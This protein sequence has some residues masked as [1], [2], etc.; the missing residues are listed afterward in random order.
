MQEGFGH[1]YGM[2]LRYVA[3]RIRYKAGAREY[4]PEGSVNGESFQA[5][6]AGE[7]EAGRPLMVA[8]FGSQEAR[9]TAW[10]HAVRSGYARA[11]PRYV[12]NR[13]ETGPGFFPA[14]SDNIVRFGAL[15]EEAATEL[16]GLAYWDSFM[17]QY[18]YEEICPS[19]AV[20][21][22]LENLEPY[23]FQDSPWSSALAGK[24]VLVVHPFAESIRAQY[25][26]REKLFRG[27]CFPRSSSL[28]SF[29]PKQS[30]GTAMNVMGHGSRPLPP[31]SEKSTGASSISQSS[32]AV[33]TGFRSQRTSRRW[34]SKRSISAEQPRCSSVSGG[35]VGISSP[36]ALSCTT[37][38]GSG[39]QR[40]RGR[41]TPLLSRAGATGDRCMD[42]G[43]VA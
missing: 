36:S 16:D 15:M 2:A 18:L 13:M 21:T 17:Q 42:L 27:G 29:R 9:A 31:L 32:A 12:W 28:P 8:R 19:T 40:V 39:P 34:G 4:L 30:R 33:P 35:A 14:N 7:I 38:G 20:T 22:Y 1:F 6:L 25:A 3:R 10:S 24:R 43:Q 23:R 41:R 37:S 5:W 26:R 11:I